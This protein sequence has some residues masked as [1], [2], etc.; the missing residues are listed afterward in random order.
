MSLNLDEDYF[1]KIGALNKP[2]AFLR[3]LH[4][5]GLAFI[6][7]FWILKIRKAPFPQI[8][9]CIRYHTSNFIFHVDFIFILFTVIFS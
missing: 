7:L 5:P 1:E 2:A 3:L 9:A 8:H 4:Y 6:L